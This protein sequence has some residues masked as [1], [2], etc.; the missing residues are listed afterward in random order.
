MQDFTETPNQQPPTAVS[1]VPQPPPER[2]RTALQASA[3]RANGAKSHGPVTPEGKAM[4]VR[5]RRT[6]GLLSK[7][8]LIGGESPERFESVSTGILHRFNPADEVELAIAQSFVMA[9]W[10]QRRCWDFEAVTFNTEMANHAE[11]PPPMA[12]AKAWDVLAGQSGSFRLLYRYERGHRRDLSRSLFDIHFCRTHLPMPADAPHDDDPPHDDPPHDDLPHDDL[13]HTD[14]PHDD[15]PLDDQPHDDPPQDDLPQDDPPNDDPPN[16]DPP[17]DDPPH[18]DPPH[19]DAE[20]QP[21]QPGPQLDARAWNSR[22][23]A[24]CPF[25]P[26]PVQPALSSTGCP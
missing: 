13:P 23:E 14:P 3:S 2:R 5:N 20:S 26:E 18:T 7:D 12:A 1:P 9:R 22:H 25:E 11:L 16:D 19:T 8:L 4:A 10:R 17:H 6:H 15:P 24:I 21:P